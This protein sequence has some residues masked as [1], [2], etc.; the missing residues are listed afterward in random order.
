MSGSRKIE[1]LAEAATVLLALLLSGVLV[2]AFLLKQPSDHPKATYCQP[3]K[4]INLKDY[5][6]GVDWPKGVRTLILALSTRAQY[7]SDIAPFYNRISQERAKDVRFLAIFPGV[8]GQDVEGQGRR[9][10]KEYGVH[11]DDVRRVNFSAMEID[12]TPLLVLLDDSGTVTDTWEGE[13][14]ANE[15]EAVIAT[16]KQSP[17][18][19]AEAAQAPGTKRIGID[20]DQE[21]PTDAVRFVRITVGGTEVLPGRYQKPYLPGKP[22]LADDH[23]LEDLSFTLKNRTSKM[24]VSLQFAYMFAEDESLTSSVEWWQQLGE[25]PEITLGT[26]N[27]PGEVIPKGTGKPLG[28]APGTEMTVSLRGQAEAIRAAVQDRGQMPFAQVRHCV[29][30]IDLAYFDDGMRWGRGEL[31]YDYVDKRSPNSWIPMDG[32]YFPGELNPTERV[33]YH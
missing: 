8:E 27:H 17:S 5:L 6:P 18:A 11:V 12:A 13:L 29:L 30:A 7:H 15:E 2:K 19:V 3:G 26:F 32:S 9:Y 20:I 14:P 1:I 22:L 4:G 21:H 24:I 31:P 33:N 10:L 25:V 28:F 23:W 16:V